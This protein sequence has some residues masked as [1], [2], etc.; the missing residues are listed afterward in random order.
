MHVVCVDLVESVHVN[1]W[2]IIYFK[3]SAI[4]RIVIILLCI[5]LRYVIHRISTD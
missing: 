2:V 3:M 4:Y 1:E 5:V